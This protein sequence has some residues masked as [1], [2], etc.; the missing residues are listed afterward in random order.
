MLVRDTSVTLN[1]NQL[2]ILVYLGVIAS[3]LGFSLWNLGATRVTA[4]T[5]A[6]MNNLKIPL[7]VAVSLHVFSETADWPR[8]LISGAFMFAAIAVAES[9]FQSDT[10]KYQS[11][12]PI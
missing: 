7:A 12:K 3:G 8:L 6:A 10:T 1:T 5:L 2:W 9:W 11:T 4:G